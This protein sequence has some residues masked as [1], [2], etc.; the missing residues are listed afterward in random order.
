M[1]D[2]SKDHY[3]KYIEE[4]DKDIFD[5]GLFESEIIKYEHDKY[6][7]IIGKKYKPLQEKSPFIVD[8][9]FNILF[10]HFLRKIWHYQKNHSK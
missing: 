1:N 4:C 6:E 3:R 10:P 9:F 7:L 5:Y 2:I 8:I